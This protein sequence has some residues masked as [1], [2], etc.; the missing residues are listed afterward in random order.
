VPEFEYA[1]VPQWL[2]IARGP[3]SSMM[4]ISF[5]PICSIAAFEEMPTKLPSAVRSREPRSR[6]GPCRG[7]S[8]WRRLIQV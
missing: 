8:I 3:D 7:W 6:W 1:A 4:V 5:S 2:A